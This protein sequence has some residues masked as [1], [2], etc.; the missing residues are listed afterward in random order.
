MA[1][2]CEAEDCYALLKPGDRVV[3]MVRGRYFQEQITPTYGDFVSD[4]DVREWHEHCFK[5][6]KLISQ[7]GL[8]NASSAS[9]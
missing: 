5:E 4:P 7:A 2:R 3:Q 8:T 6:F 9:K 1:H